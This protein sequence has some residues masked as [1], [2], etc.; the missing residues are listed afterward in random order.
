MQMTYHHPRSFP[1]AAQVAKRRSRSPTQKYSSGIRRMQ[2]RILS[3]RTLVAAHLICT[4]PVTSAE[5]ERSF[6]TL[7]R[8]KTYLRATMNS[9]RESGLALM[10][11]HHGRQIDISETGESLLE[12][13]CDFG[14]SVVRYHIFYSFWLSMECS[15]V[16]VTPK[17][18]FNRNTIW[19]PLDASP[20]VP[21]REK[22]RRR[23]SSNC[24]F[25]P[26]I[27]RRRREIRPNPSKTIQFGLENGG[28]KHHSKKFTK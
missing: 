1:L 4:F 10:N 2:P 24:R 9:E 19:S 15:E 7:R 21:W 3:K 18:K 5:R 8:L 26:T 23:R 20:V 22:S 13:R 12:W 14:S 11:I 6:S 27:W 17:R 28:F 25:E 16:N